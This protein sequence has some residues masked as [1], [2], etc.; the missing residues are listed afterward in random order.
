MIWG[1]ALL[2]AV[3]YVLN[4]SDSVAGLGG[5]GLLPSE[6]QQHYG[7]RP[8]AGD[9]LVA[10]PGTALG[11]PASARLTVRGAGPWAAQASP[12]I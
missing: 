8:W 12:L 10:C 9:K 4:R 3:G 5:C 7:S 6:R 1:Q 2:W 11:A